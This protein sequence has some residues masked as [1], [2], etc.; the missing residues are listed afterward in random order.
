MIGFSEVNKE[1]ESKVAS[2]K[3]ELLTTKMTLDERDL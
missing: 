2:L 1:R 3:Q